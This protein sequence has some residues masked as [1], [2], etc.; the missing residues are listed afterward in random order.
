MTLS[1]NNLPLDESFKAYLLRLLSEDV[2]FAHRIQAILVQR[3]ISTV[4]QPLA[5]A[6]P[7]RELPYWKNRPHAKPRN[8]KP[9]AI[10]K[11]TITELQEIWKD[12]PSAELLIQSLTP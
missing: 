1:L 6:L 3:P 12:A 5:P 11:K 8:P 10:S 2:E 4:V 7:Y 9:F